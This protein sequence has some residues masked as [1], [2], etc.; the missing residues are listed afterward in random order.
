MKKLII[1]VLLL[2]GCSANYIIP[3]GKAQYDFERAKEE[4][5][6]ITGAKL[7]GFALGNPVFVVAVMGG[8]AVYNGVVEYRFRNCM[9][10]RGFEVEQ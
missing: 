7:G 5:Q 1:A 2:A 6:A 8:G 9:H 10:E 4:C 3:D